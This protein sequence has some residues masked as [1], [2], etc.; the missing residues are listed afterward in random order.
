MHCLALVAFRVLCLW[1]PVASIECT[2]DP[3]TRRWGKKTATDAAKK[4]QVV[5]VTACS[6]PVIEEFGALGVDGQC[7][8]HLPVQA[9]TGSRSPAIAAPA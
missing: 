2:Q 3:E 6:E 5:D 8:G 7:P 4:N 1:G 9:S